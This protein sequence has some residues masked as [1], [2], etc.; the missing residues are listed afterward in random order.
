M[1]AHASDDGNAFRRIAAAYITPVVSTLQELSEAVNTLCTDMHER[2]DVDYSQQIYA[3][4]HRPLQGISSLWLWLE[5]CE[6]IMLSRVHA[7]ATI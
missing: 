3:K 1:R 4:V 2:G 5:V 7:A 6:R